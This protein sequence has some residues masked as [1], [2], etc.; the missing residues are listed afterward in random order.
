[1]S[2]HTKAL[3]ASSYLHV[4]TV[5]L[6]PAPSWVCV[7]P[8]ASP[9]SS[10]P[11]PPFFFLTV[12]SKVLACST[13]AAA[14]APCPLIAARVEGLREEGKRKEEEGYAIG[15]SWLA[16]SLARRLACFLIVAWE[17]GREEGWE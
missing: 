17:G 9:L 15:C 16:E 11:S 2:T 5:A 14:A 3:V 12:C 7:C 13:A 1:M 6:L 4:T 8:L 10:P